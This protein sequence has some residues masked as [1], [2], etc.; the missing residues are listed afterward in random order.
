MS[1][2]KKK[3]EKK[4]INQIEKEIKTNN[5]LSIEA[6]KN[7]ILALRFIGKVVLKII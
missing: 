1:D 7:S 5:S 2:L 6:R 4:T 3:Y